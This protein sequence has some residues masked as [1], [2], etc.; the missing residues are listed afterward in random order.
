[1]VFLVRAKT[2]ALITLLVLF[3]D[4]L[5][6]Y[7]QNSTRFRITVSVVE[8]VSH[9]P[10]AHAHVRLLADSIVFDGFTNR[11]GTV[12]FEGIPAGPYGI[13]VNADGYAF[14]EPSRVAVTA[15]AA[16]S[17]VG[18]QTRLTRIGRAQSRPSPRPNAAQSLGDSDPAAQIAGGVGAAIT[19]IPAISEDL[20]NNSILI[21]NHDSSTTTTT[22]NGAPIF[23][24]GAKNQL[25]LLNSDIFSSGGLNTAGVAGSPDAALA[26]QSYDPTIDWTGILQERPSA[27]GGTALSVQERGTSGRIGLSAIHSASESGNQLDG[28]FFADASGSA[29]FHRANN[30]TGG[31]TF[32][33]RYGFDPNHII[34]VDFGQLYANDPLICADK[35]GPLPCGFGPSNQTHS[36]ISFTQVRDS[37]ILERFSLDLNV[38]QSKSSTALDFGNELNAGQPIGFTSD[39]ISRRNGI[40]AKFGF[41]YGRSQVANLS[42]TSY[43][44]SS[45]FSGSFLSASFPSP[46]AASSF[47]SVQFNLPLYNTNRAKL[48]AGVGRDNGTDSSRT[49]FDANGSFLL[50]SRDA[51]TAS[52]KAGHLSSP[53][54]SFNGVDMPAALS[55]DCAD[56]K[57]LGNGPTLPAL[58][59]GAT[60]QLRAGISHTGA[61]VSLDLQAFRDTDQNAAVTGVVPAISLSPSF[62][63]ASYVASA[64]QAAL[65]SCGT[66]LGLS[67]TSLFY[68]VTA[69]AAQTITDGFDASAKIDVGSRAHVDLGYSLGRARAFGL[70]IPFLLGSN[71]L[72]GAQL[73]FHPLH[74]ENATIRYGVSRASTLLLAM[75]YSGS[76]NAFRQ[77]PLTTIDLG[78]RL[79]AAHGDF[80]LG[81]QNVS[82]ANGMPFATFQPF[83]QISR[84]SSP[85]TL[86][87]RY[88][89]AL[90]RQDI[91]KVAYASPNISA[92]GGSVIVLSPFEPTVRPDWLVPATD[93][94]LCGPESIA[95]ANKYLSAVRAFDQMVRDAGPNGNVPEVTIDGMTMR[96]RAASSEASYAIEIRLD[97]SKRRSLTPFTRC[98]NIHEGSYDDAKRLRLYVPGWQERDADPSALYF[99]PQVGFYDPPSIPNGTR[100]PAV[101]RQGLP[102]RAPSD[103]FAIESKTCPSNYAAAVADSL[104][105]LRNYITAFYAGG[106]PTA[107]DGFTIASHVAKAESWL[108]IRSD[109]RF[110]ANA[111]ASCTDA[112]MTTVAELA[113]QGLSG[114]A[115]P[116]LNYAPS[117]GF[118]R[119]NFVVTR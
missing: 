65:F 17:V 49:T 40:I 1:L 87:A 77:R 60:T 42:I 33:A 81:L 92:L 57:A 85:R 41:L 88:R 73:P 27:F 109:D 47:S 13:S 5:V 119:V 67:T 30:L 112:P 63:G 39:T 25:S 59:P 55:F 69:P 71:L 107:P 79:K 10:I 80:T 53:Q 15:D 83:P 94:P 95:S 24:N 102:A 68:N 114:A 96:M 28:L 4:P 78:L 18:T 2:L 101:A 37:L 106:H 64:N 38:F 11:S 75:N 29:Y 23:P 6:G 93:S 116:S 110:F 56:G 108:D 89:I 51:I 34:Y 74:R 90:G 22:L 52:Y 54:S 70:G 58:V 43:A 48:M 44:D 14:A 16:V 32:T 8:Q 86:S 104:K 20:S 7:A 12:V 82:N 9:R 84:P 103:P 3:A 19:K 61:R 50:T 72:P 66:A 91:D 105:D 99:A 31:D 100:T 98:A 111:I 21:H 76:D 36:A 62:F 113:R 26:L 45:T 35:F 118:Y 97:P 115:V 117:V 46:P